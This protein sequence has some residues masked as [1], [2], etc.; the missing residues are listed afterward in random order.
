MLR[1][2]RSTLT[3]TTTTMLAR[4]TRF[5]D[6]ELHTLRGLVR[7]GDVCLDV[8]AAAGLY[9]QTLSQ[10]VGPAGTVHSI[11]PLP[12][13]HPLWTRVLG[14]WE[15]PNVT[16]HVLA[17]G[18]E[19]GQAAMRVPFDR[20]GAATSRAFL[21]WNTNGVGSN[22]EYL[23]HVDMLVDTKTLDRFRADLD[24]TRLDF[25]KIDVEG[26]ELHVLRGGE[27]TID[28]FRPTMLIE[29][30][31]RHIDRYAHTPEDVVQWLT[32]RGYR[33]YAWCDGWQP[34]SQVCLHA[35][36]YLFR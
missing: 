21:D 36:N 13:S 16:R 23:Y 33:M 7:P 20:H 8:G 25:V 22:A 26:G 18:A 6:T 12:F 2:D 35:N 9:S 3:T 29:I 34:V 1:L 30:E 24:L 17:L 15:R 28:T 10:L 19:T 27:K 31:A 32:S 11:E 14:A 4:R 5:L